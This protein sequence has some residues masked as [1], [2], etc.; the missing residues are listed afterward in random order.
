MDAPA[1]RGF[2]AGFASL[3]VV[4][5]F[6]YAVTAASVADSRGSDPAGNALSDAFAAILAGL[7]WIAIAVL[8][9]MARARGAMVSWAPWALFVL[10]PAAVV[11]FFF[12][13]GRFAAGDRSALVVVFALPLLPILYALWARVPA[14]QAWLRPAGTSAALLAMMGVLSL[15][16]IAVGERAALPSPRA[17][18][19]RAAAEKARLE[20]AAKARRETQEHAA[21]AFA[22]LGPDSHIAEYLPYLHDRGFADQALAGIQKVKSRQAD[23]AALLEQRP[24]GDLADLWQFN[25]LATREVCEAYANAFLAVANHINTTRSDHLA[26]A[27][28]LEWQL[29]NLKWLVR[30]KCDLSGPLDRAEGN[31]K[32][33]ADSDRLRN[34][35]LTLSELKTVR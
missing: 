13:M 34:F 5:L 35:A 8:L 21:A 30:S 6:L 32:A 11:A 15:G 26:V 33:V 20:Q 12:A 9:V 16:T 3:L 18:E 27:M 25:V 10:V 28:D 19:D 22:A 14:L 4:A 23:A 31:I 7:L 24:L 29:P 1:R 2:P 17:Q